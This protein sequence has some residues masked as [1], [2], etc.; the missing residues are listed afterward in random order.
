[1]CKAVVELCNK[2]KWKDETK[3]SYVQRCKKMVER[4][5][6]INWSDKTKKAERRN[7]IK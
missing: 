2:N 7:K 3:L 4:C 5:N 6:K 1:M